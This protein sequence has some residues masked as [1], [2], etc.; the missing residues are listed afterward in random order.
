MSLRVFAFLFLG[1]AV[2]GS[3]TPISKLVADAFPTFVG[4]GLRVLL[5]AV[6]L[7][8]FVLRDGLKLQS[9]TRRDV[10][11]V[12]VI[13]LVGMFGFSVF[14]VYG[15]RLVSG[16]AGSIVMSTTPAVTAVAAFIFLREQFGWRK[17]A[18]AALAVLGVLLLNVLSS[19]EAEAS[20]L[21][22]VLGSLLV[23]AAVCCEAT[24]T[25]LGKLATDN[26]TPLRLSF[27]AAAASLPLFAVLAA[28][29][30]PNVDWPG[31]GI[32]DW[33]AVAWWGAGTMALGSVLWYSGV[34]Q[35]EGSIAAGF[36]G[37]M[38]VSALVL[39]YVVLGE[40]FLWEHFLGFAVVFVGVLLVAHAHANDEPAK[41][42]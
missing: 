10:V 39:S 29:Q 26:V 19:P 28:L 32:A 15:M 11:L 31:V 18:A 7:L 8:P 3:A 42:N 1:M 4:A 20:G 35:V 38:P 17:A 16:V 9:L 13:A 33:L 22:L 23:F 6:V 12:L 37:V 25:L 14:M 36:M 21:T 27:F 40:P 41:T 24:Y 2:F 30:A 34:E 5:G